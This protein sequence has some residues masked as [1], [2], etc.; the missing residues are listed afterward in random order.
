MAPKGLKV[1]EQM[2]QSQANW[3]RRDLDN[4]YEHFG[5]VIRHGSRHDIVRHPQFP[6]LWATVPRHNEVAKAYIKEAIKLIEEYL[7]LRGVDTSKEAEKDEPD[8]S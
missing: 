4:L 5:F 3:S 8:N 7:A 1:L 6:L 2:R